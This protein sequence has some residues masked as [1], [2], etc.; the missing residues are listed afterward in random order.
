MSNALR[1]FDPNSPEFRAQSVQ[2]RLAT[3]N[4][5]AAD[6]RIQRETAAAQ[7]AQQQAQQQARAA[8]Q[9][10]VLDTAALRKAGVTPPWQD[11]IPNPGAANPQARA[12]YGQSTVPN[13]PPPQGAQAAAAAEA[14]AAARYQQQMGRPAPG[15]AAPGVGAAPTAAPP[16]AAPGGLRKAADW[17]AGKASGAG[18]FLGGAGTVVSAGAD[19]IVEGGKVK[20]VY[21]R[22]GLGYDTATQAA[23]GTARVAG[24][25]AGAWAGM[26]AGALAGGAG[27][28]AVG[29]VGAPVGAAVGGLAGGIAGYFGGEALVDGAIS[30]GREWLGLDPTS[31]ADK[32][33]AEKA[34]QGR[35]AT[36]QPTAQ[37]A[38]APDDRN[39]YAAQNQAK[40]DAL[41]L[42]EKQR[43]E[44]EQLRRLGESYES[45][46]GANGARPDLGYGPIGDR[47]QL[48]NEQAAIM[49]PQG[50]VTFTL[51]DNGSPTFS[52]TDVRGQVAYTNSDGKPLPGGGLRGQFSNFDVVPA[53]AYVG[54]RGFAYS[55]GGGT[56]GGGAGPQGTS[57][58]GNALRAENAQRARALGADTAGLNPWQAQQYLN[59]V[60]GAQA[61]NAAGAAQAAAD[62]RSGKWASDLRDP[63]TLALRNAGVGSR[64]HSNTAEVFAANKARRGQID[65]AWDAIEGREKRDVERLQSTNTLRGQQMNAEAQMYSSDNTLRGN[66]YQ[67]ELTAATAAQK[68]EADRRA[69]AYT[70]AKD[71]TAAQKT[72][73]EEAVNMFRREGDKDAGAAEQ[74]LRVADQVM[75]GFSTMDTES[76]VRARP[77]VEAAVGLFDRM[78]A[79]TPQGLWEKLTSSNKPELAG[80]PSIK[81]W[82]VGRS[83]GGDHYITNP[84]T[85]QTIT[86]GSGLN[87]MQIKMLEN[88]T[89]SGS[90][91]P[92]KNK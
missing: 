23:E 57:A 6:V 43:A 15:P 92:P 1:N 62:D 47:T 37:P 69:A 14:E 83:F 71:Y 12:M 45:R 10:P 88:A 32:V 84:K 74:R 36:A 2:E 67:A 28:A 66:M 85:N 64:I 41:A 70:Q 81:G 60:A 26:K 86:L 89:Q 16:A 21:D 52:G 31:P 53:G 29:G 90:F 56:G 68:A 58:A 39:P 78:K 44:D 19:A 9:R 61:A 91:L 49:N 48:T 65:K 54:E 72:A 59:E 35:A 46:P 77:Q 3:A 80:L 50:R 76:K 51:D 20:D 63:R 17:V 75:P 5:A 4:Q 25:A 22:S 42:A 79:Q 7:Q 55:T 11:P 38:A 30:K 13:N 24:K 27:G 18:R 33:A 40:L 73:R 8:A 34:A 87:E 82:K